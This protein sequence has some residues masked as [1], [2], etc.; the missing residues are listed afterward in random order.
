MKRYLVFNIGCLECN[1]TSNVV[2]VYDTKEEAEKVASICDSK[3][4]WR[5]CGQNEFQVFDLL[6][7]QAEEYT[8]AL[9]E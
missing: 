5:D 9:G 1:V 6:A 2:G 7:P 4:F 3:L 8:E